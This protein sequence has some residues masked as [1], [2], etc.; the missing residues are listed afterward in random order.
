MP[1]SAGED[2]RVR[3]QLDVGPGDL[4]R[5]AV[6]H[7]RAVHLRHLVEHRRRVVDVELDPA[8]EQVRDVVG[9]ADDDQPAGTGVDDVV[10]SL[11]QSAARERPHRGPSG[12]GDLDVLK[13]REAHPQTEKPSLTRMAK[14]ALECGL[15]IPSG[16]LGMAFVKAGR[17][18]S[19]EG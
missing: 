6:E 4:G 8:G 18:V 2:R 14:S 15:L 9:V 10:D 19:S 12:A 1:V 3:H 11:A 16:Q 13:A 17:Q 7:D 5:L